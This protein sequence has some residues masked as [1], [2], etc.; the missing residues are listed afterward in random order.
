MNARLVTFGAVA[1]LLVAAFGC[2]LIVGSDP[3]P[4]SCEEGK[5]GACPEGEFC[6]G[7]RCIQGSSSDTTPPPPPDGEVPDGPVVPTDG[8][9]DARTD[10][11]P[12]S[13]TFGAACQGDRD[14]QSGI[15]GTDGLLGQA[16]LGQGALCTRSCC[17]STDCPSGAA[18]LSPGTGGAYCVPGG[19]L[20]DRTFPASGG[21]APGTL[22][23]NNTECRS[24]LC[25][26]LGGLG[27]TK[28]CID[29]CCL[30]RDCTGGS[31]CTVKAVAGK[32]TGFVCANGPSTRD[33]GA[34]CSASGDS[35]CRSNFCI[36][37]TNPSLD[38]CAARCCTHA[39]CGTGNS[40]TLNFAGPTLS[41][42]VQ[43]CIAGTGTAAKSTC[44]T[45]Q[46]CSSGLCELEANGQPDG[47]TSRKV[48]RDLCCQD[49]DCPTNERCLPSPANPR[50]LRCVP[51]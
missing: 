7:G 13:G 30:D 41:D 27:N 43:H 28:R 35:A 14:C 42:N 19:R 37:F 21:A 38:N 16:L 45:P 34:L 5:A 10:G 44:N 48:C 25:A 22:C 11:G 9:S 8:G 40:C 33:A 15:C 50:A 46:D 2:Q 26:D 4:F 12:P 24:G 1:G 51:R 20:P 31:S 49:G 47:S 29:N 17:T 6:S 3:P 18:C 23:T 32:F 39:Q 36:R